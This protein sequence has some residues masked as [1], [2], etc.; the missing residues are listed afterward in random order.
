[1][2]LKVLANIAR[3]LD[4]IDLQRCFIEGRFVYPAL[5]GQL[6]EYRLKEFK[7][8]YKEKF[9]FFRIRRIRHFATYI[10]DLI[11]QFS[12][13]LS[14]LPKSK[15]KPSKIKASPYE[16]VMSYLNS[17]KQLGYDPEKYC[18][19]D[20]SAI[21]TATNRN[22]LQGSIDAVRSQLKAQNK[23]I[24]DL[25]L[26]MIEENYEEEAKSMIDRYSEILKDQDK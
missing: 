21:I 24:F 12:Y 22:A 2:N 17:L 16:N 18:L 26:D 14:T 9:F 19:K 20:A 15:G 23:A 11:N 6:G 8:G 4:G 25:E 13:E 7:K 1:M 10:L 5:F 3:L